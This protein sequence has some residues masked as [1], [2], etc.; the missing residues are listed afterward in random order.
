MPHRCARDRRCAL[1]VNDADQVAVAV[2][3]KVHDHDHHHHDHHYDDDDVRWLV[4]PN[5]S[6]KVG[7]SQYF[8]ERCQNP[9]HLVQPVRKVRRKAQHPI[10]TAAHDTARSQLRCEPIGFRRSERRKHSQ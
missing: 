9:R 10:R 2:H 8:V 7:M 6:T 3:V 4:A 5:A 1:R